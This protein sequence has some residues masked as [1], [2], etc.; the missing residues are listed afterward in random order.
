MSGRAR[1]SLVAATRNDGKLRELRPLFAAAGFTLEDLRAVGLSATIAGEADVER[2]ES[3]AE[4]AL[5][6]ARFFHD[7]S[8]G[9]PCVADDSG[10]EVAALHGAPGVR[11]RRWAERDGLSGAAL[12]DANNARLVSAM[13]GVADHAA[14]FVCAAAY[15]DGQRDMVA[16]G[17]VSGEIVERPR[18][19]NGFG[20]DAHFVSADLGV[21]LAEAT[22]EAKARVSH[23]ARAFAKLIELLPRPGS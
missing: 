20:Y 9:L 8:G 14:R 10:L 12:D 19:S 16:L 3:Y 7:A 2:F 4:N 5:A 13:V 6:K 22:L 17:T 1:G 23:R 15:C 21:T 11:S 18:G